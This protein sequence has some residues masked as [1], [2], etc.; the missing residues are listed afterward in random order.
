MT[1]K[2]PKICIFTLGCKVNLYD[3]DAMLKIFDAAGFEAEEGL[4]KADIYIINTC[5]VTAEAEK[6]SRQAVAR[7]KKLNE[8]AE[9]YICGCASQNNPEQ[10]D[11]KG[12]TYI[13][14]AD[15]KTELARSIVAKYIDVGDFVFDGDPF[16]L[17]D[18]FDESDGV[19]NLKTRH[20][21]KVQDGCNNFCSYCIIP[22]LRGRS[23][24][25]DEEAIY[26][27]LN[28]VRNKIKE[29][30]VTGINLSAYGLDNGSSL[31]RL[32]EGF[33]R[34]G[35]LRVRLG[36]LE[37]GVIDR[38]LLETAKE[39]E[40]FCP[41][42]HLSLQSGDD[43]V[44]RAMNR[45]YTS[46]QYYQKAQLIREYFPEAAITTDIIVGF[47]TETDEQFENSYRFAEKVGF[48]DIHAFAY[49]SR[50]G[51]VA[52][53][54]KPLSPEIVA[55]RMDKMMEVKRELREAYLMSQLSKPQ[56]VL[57]ETRKDGLWE[58]HAANYIKVY[59]ENGA[60]NEC[61]KVIPLRLYAD[62]VTD[63][64]PSCESMRETK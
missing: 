20:F 13:V 44:L 62:G 38:R 46:E 4:K 12:V 8:N 14:G 5:A 51:T 40:R 28:G 49:S 31:A 6:K 2:L 47:P 36:S 50:K 32:L 3:S 16:G 1:E 9:I 15:K 21:I 56:E 24:S 25:R 39:L 59:S 61:A 19:I 63:C 29:V 35:D 41:H 30:V 52:G 26:A 17:S 64:V 18:K 42:F 54:L 10:F 11:K 57:F 55:S 60:R 37:A 22:Y 33:K 45:R 7:I 27:E 34:Y 53:K 58:G 43:D 23:R 48:S